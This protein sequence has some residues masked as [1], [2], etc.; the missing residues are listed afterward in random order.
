[1]RPIQIC[2]ILHPACI[3]GTALEVEIFDHYPSARA[4]TYLVGSCVEHG[5][6]IV[7]PLDADDGEIA[8]RWVTGGT[9]LDA[10]E[11]LQSGDIRPCRRCD[12]TGTYEVIGRDLA[13]VRE[14]ECEECYGE[15][16][17]GL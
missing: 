17:L 1:M 7:C 6:T 12:G 4:T 3:T 2:Q 16:G 10:V 8:A 9:V 13:D 11:W 15:G 5:W 14:V